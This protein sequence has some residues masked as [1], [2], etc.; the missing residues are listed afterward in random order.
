[1]FR[2]VRQQ[3]TPHP[4]PP[5]P[6]AFRDQLSLYKDFLDAIIKTGVVSLPIPAI[7]IYNY[8][9][10]VGHQDLFAASVLSLSGLSALLQ[11]FLLLWVVITLCIL[12]PSGIL[13][14]TLG[15]T[16]SN[17]PAKGIPVFVLLSS[18][19]WATFYAIAGY[20]DDGATPL[21]WRYWTS[22]ALAVIVI[23]ITLGALA[24]WSPSWMNV[25]PR[26]EFNTD[27]WSR[28]LQRRPARVAGILR[29][30]FLHRAWRCFWV[31]TTFVG[32]GLYAV[33]A[34]YVVSTLADSWDLPKHGWKVSAILF[35]IILASFLPGAFYLKVRAA[36][37]S[38][39]S[40]LKT[41]LLATLAITYAAVFYG[42][43]VEPIALVAMKAMGVIDNTPRT[44]EVIKADERPVYQALG[45]RP[46]SGDRFVQA[47]IRFQFGD[48][49]LICP[50][51][52]PLA[53]EP[54]PSDEKS[55]SPLDNDSAQ[56]K[57]AAS[58]KA[59]KIDSTGCLTP[60]K[61]EIRVIDLP[62]KFTL[63]STP[64]ATAQP[65]KPKTHIAHRKHRA[66][67]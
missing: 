37:G 50:K 26:S 28:K 25:V 7:L 9:K 52:Y 33:L 56:P 60:M 35:F 18:V 19:I 6:P 47:F 48:V 36:E 20:F 2:R 5:E 53:G 64:P 42:T 29:A 44:Y 67:C 13:G 51:S 43:S 8:L 54:S 16:R 41:A 32:A 10:L 11:I 65:D 57:Q 40:A 34:I 66:R 46:Q 49:K 1:M 31:A 63:T 24:W 39:G 21:T 12:M 17:F 59:N 62:D 15:G 23:W 4:Q 38:H 14:G 30:I 3:G 61:D 22:A 27:D 45:Y 58:S 55:H